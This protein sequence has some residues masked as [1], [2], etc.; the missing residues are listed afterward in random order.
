MILL[1]M[2]EVVGLSAKLN[3]RKQSSLL[4]PKSQRFNSRFGVDPEENCN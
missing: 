2:L 3:P 4:E 1:P